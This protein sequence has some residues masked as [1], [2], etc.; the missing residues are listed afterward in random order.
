MKDASPGMSGARR[1]VATLGLL[2]VLGWGSTFYLLAV[3]GRPIA[4]D[5][6]WPFTWVIGG[7]SVALLVASLVSPFV[8]RTI[9]ARG[10]RAV[11]A[12]SSVLIAAG[13]SSLALS[14]NLGAYLAAWAVIG[15][16]MGAGLYDPAFSTLG[17]LYGRDA[18][19]VI[20]AVTLFGGFASTVAWPS[21]AFLLNHVGWRATCWTYAALELVVGV[22]AYLLLIPRP[23]ARP[24]APSGP[25]LDNGAA[26]PP[27]KQRL[28][29]FLLG[30]ILTLSAS[31][32]SFISTHLLTLLQARGLDLAAA[33]ALGALIGPSQ[34]GARILEMTFGRNFHPV[35]GMLGGTVLV[36][37][38]MALLWSGSP[39][40]ALALIAYG[41]GNGISTVVRGTVPL[42]LFGPARYPELMGRLG[43]PILLA[44]A[45][46]PAAGAPLIE[47]GGASLTF[48]ALTFIALVNVGLALILLRLCRT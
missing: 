29:L 33:V 20:A 21:T 3:L 38:G 11:L 7:L 12:T 10:G 1:I 19:R 6:G 9:A 4:A 45:L 43:L 15:C 16:G 28:A 17:Q 42:V 47:H 23:A 46:A 27:E 26:L 37:I 18:R 41:M 32:L 30:V 14:A 25:S 39:V 35:W 5:T 44:M 34:V 13:L 2:Q 22:P 40:P 31:L 8:G 48:A 36:A 24:A